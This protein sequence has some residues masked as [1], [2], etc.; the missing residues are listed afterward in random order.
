VAQCDENHRHCKAYRYR[1]RRAELATKR[2]AA[3]SQASADKRSKKAPASAPSRSASTKAGQLTPTLS[4]PTLSCGFV[5]APTIDSPPF[6][7][8]ATAPLSQAIVSRP[9]REATLKRKVYEEDEGEEEEEDDD[10]EKEKEVEEEIKTPNAEEMAQQ[11]TTSAMT[12]MYRVAPQGLHDV[13][14]DM[15]GA[16]SHPVEQVRKNLS[17]ANPA[18]FRLQLVY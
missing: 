8:A 3:S 12:P 2:T 14:G 10:E 11:M 1:R 13:R 5:R 16:G 15:W 7:A 18:P 6:R 4:R 9:R 17:C